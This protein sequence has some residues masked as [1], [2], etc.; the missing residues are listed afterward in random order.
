MGRIGP[1]DISGS[2]CSKIETV[3]FANIAHFAYVRQP[4]QL[5]RVR[6]Q[7]RRRNVTAVMA[8]NETYISLNTLTGNT[9]GSDGYPCPGRRRAELSPGSPR[10]SAYATAC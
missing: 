8:I 5:A 4:Y 7:K 1:T 6:R 2:S 10:A 3:T 9:I